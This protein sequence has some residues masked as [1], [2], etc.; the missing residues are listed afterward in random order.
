[1]HTV[2]Q[3]HFVGNLISQIFWNGKRAKLAKLNCHEIINFTLTLM[4]SFP[5]SQS[6][7]LCLEKLAKKKKK[8]AAKLTCFTV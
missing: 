7:D 8:K 2:K 4:V 3:V 6:F 1:M 5:F